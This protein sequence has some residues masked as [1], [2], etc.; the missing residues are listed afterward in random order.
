MSS[1]AKHYGVRL[2]YIREQVHAHNIVWR[3]IKTADQIADMLTKSLA[4][5]K[6]RQHTDKMLVP[7]FTNLVNSVMGEPSTPWWTSAGKFQDSFGG[8]ASAVTF[9]AR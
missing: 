7:Q 5:A 2:F 6:Q 1:K 9:R 8:I 4:S 3:H